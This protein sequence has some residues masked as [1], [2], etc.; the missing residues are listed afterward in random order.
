LPAWRSNHHLQL[1]IVIETQ[2]TSLEPQIVTFNQDNQIQD[3]LTYSVDLDASDRYSFSILDDAEE[4][5]A[6]PA[7]G[8]TAATLWLDHAPT[9]AKG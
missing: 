1:R 7:K 2:L 8:S 4:P 5:L 3:R 6:I 9:V